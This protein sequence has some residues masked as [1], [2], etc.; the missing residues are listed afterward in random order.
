M[1]SSAPVACFALMADGE[2]QNR[3]VGL[4][5]TVKSH[6]AGMTARNCQFPEP[7]LDRTTHKRMA[8]QNRNRLL[9]EPK[10]LYCGWRVVLDQEAG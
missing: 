8:F 2:N 9:Y 6:I 4:L 1:F 5:E 10:R 7:W 3:I